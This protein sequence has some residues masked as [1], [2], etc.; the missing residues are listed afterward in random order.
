MEHR[1]V[2]YKRTA[3]LIIL[4]YMILPFFSVVWAAELKS[5]SFDRDPGWEGLNN[6]IEVDEA[7]TVTQDFGY[8]PTNFAGEAKGEVGGTVTRASRPAFY[9]ARIATKTL[10]DKLSA[11]GTFAVTECHGGAAA[12]FGW[13]SVEGRGAAGRP[14]NALALEFAG[15]SAG[16]RLTVRLTAAS[17]RAIG[18]KV[19]PFINDRKKVKGPGNRDFDAVQPNGTRYTWKLDYDPEANDGKGRIEFLVRGDGKQKQPW[20][21]QPLVIDVPGE[22]RQAGATFTH[23][24]LL[25]GLKPGRSMKVYFDDVT[26]DGMSL[27]FSSDPGWEA[28][29]NRTTYQEQEQHGA[30]N[31]GFS[32]KTSLAGGSPGEVGGTMWRGGDYSYYADT[33][34][35]LSLENRLEASGKVTLQAGP[36]DSSVYIG[37][38]NSADQENAPSQVGNLVGIKVG[39]P[40]KVGHY[41]LPVY[42]TSKTTPIERV[43]KSQRPADVALEPSEGPILTPGKSSHWKLVYDPTAE[44]G[45]GAITV[46]VGDESITFPLKAGDKAKGANFNRFGLFTAHHGGNFLKIYFDDLHY[47]AK[48]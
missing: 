28:I 3:F 4:C 19:T 48:Q 12:A 40:S 17:N 13:F 18:Q 33:V 38:F 21:G 36:S 14:M 10:D 8:S 30:Q 5:E 47:T 20:E 25:N 27:D 44:N 23:F 32:A 26:F 42:A 22:V 35:P 37:W 43:G 29:G 34:G 9:G 6:R 24:G 1:I 2:K 11:S 15:E 45:R 7:R 16:P 31:Y 46:T 41:F 39:G